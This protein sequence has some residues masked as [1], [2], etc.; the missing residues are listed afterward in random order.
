MSV[1][2]AEAIK[3]DEIKDVEVGAEGVRVTFV[4]EE[5]KFIGGEVGFKLYR[6]WREWKQAGWN[7]I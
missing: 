6:R 7:F 4:N 3:L 5:R 1:V 2:E